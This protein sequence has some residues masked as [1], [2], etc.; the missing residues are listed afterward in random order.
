M[1][2]L[3][4]N[5]TGEE[6]YSRDGDEAITTTLW[7]ASSTTF[8]LRYFFYRFPDTKVLLFPSLLDRN[9]DSWRYLLAA[10]PV[11]QLFAAATA[12][13]IQ[14]SRSDNGPVDRVA[15]RKWRAE[16]IGRR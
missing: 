5:Y 4:C 16:S 7:V 10:H 14:T 15:R 8:L 1:V 13:S 2:L 6:K 3:K 9:V 11:D 12:V